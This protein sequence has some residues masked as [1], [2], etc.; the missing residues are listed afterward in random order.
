MT[1]SSSKH[2]RG[3]LKWRFKV[4][5]MDESESQVWARRV[6]E[7]PAD[8]NGSDAQ[9]EQ[10]RQ[11]VLRLMQTPAASEVQPAARP[12]TAAVAASS[13]VQAVTAKPG[14]QRPNA[15]PSAKRLRQSRAAIASAAAAIGAASRAKKG[16]QQQQQPARA[17]RAAPTAAELAAAVR[18]VR[19]E[20][21]ADA[22]APPNLEVAVRRSQA[23][24]RESA[25]VTPTSP[26]RSSAMT[27]AHCC[28]RCFVAWSCEASSAQ[29]R[30]RQAGAL[31]A[32]R[33]PQRRL[34]AC[35]RRWR[36]EA[37][38]LPAA[39]PAAPAPTRRR[40][41]TPQVVQRMLYR[42][43]E[44]RL[45]VVLRR[46]RQRTLLVSVIRTEGRKLGARLIS[47][48]LSQLS[49]RIHLLRQVSRAWRRWRLWV[50]RTVRT[51]Q[52][53]RLAQQQQ[54]LSDLRTRLRT[55][56]AMAAQPA[57]RRF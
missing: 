13:E 47:T 10:T 8:L 16:K 26:Q 32:R 53:E 34:A 57:P 33:R 35:W 2:K 52:A 25:A 55:S 15:A 45:S 30:R 29:R 36:L 48:R 37:A 27:D 42:W 49:L 24:L 6:Q 40:G 11:R 12:K 41:P 7:A 39:P 14:A 31:L 17:K 19:A 5:G 4:R 46:W 56:R 21:S 20:V 28:S 50:G 51:R 54:Q 44:R 1:N 18:A 43:D 23:A 22:A 3:A 9:Y 38:R